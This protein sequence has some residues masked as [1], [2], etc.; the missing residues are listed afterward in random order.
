M[1][2][3]VMHIVHP[4]R[5][6]E[7]QPANIRLSDYLDTKRGRWFL[8]Q[9]HIFDQKPL[10]TFST[11][12]GF[13]KWRQAA[14]PPKNPAVLAIAGDVLPQSPSPMTDAE[15][16]NRLLRTSE[17]AAQ[18]LMTAV[19]TMDKSRTGLFWG[20]AGVMGACA[21]AILFMVFIAATSYLAPEPDRP[22]PPRPAPG[23]EQPAPP[24]P[25]FAT[26][27]PVQ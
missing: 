11:W 17:A 27:T 15:F 13:L 14:S 7:R 4:D 21:A 1:R 12:A 24:Q 16:A 6:V 19:G 8:E 2:K 22:Q 20:M 26:T 25:W 10:E 9:R 5:V 3:I 23:M 18:D